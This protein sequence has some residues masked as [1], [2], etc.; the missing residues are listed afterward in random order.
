MNSKIGTE[1][2]RGHLHT[3]EQRLHW[4][5]KSLTKLEQRQEAEFTK[6]RQHAIN[7]LRE[8]LAMVAVEDGVRTAVKRQ[9]VNSEIVADAFAV[10][11]AT[12]D[13]PVAKRDAARAAV[14]LQPVNTNK[15]EEKF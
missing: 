7:R 1:F 6:K 5:Q 4:L 9:R 11:S 8:Q 10:T 3:S 13:W 12:E 2:L 15:T 14:N